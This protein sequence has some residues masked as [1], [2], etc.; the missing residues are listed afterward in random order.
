MLAKSL[1][2]QAANAVRMLR[3]GFTKL[4]AFQTVKLKIM[5]FINLAVF[6][7]RVRAVIKRFETNIGGEI[8]VHR[9]DAAD[10]KRSV[11]RRAVVKL[12]A[13]DR[14]LVPALRQ[15]PSDVLLLPLDRLP[16]FE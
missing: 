3:I 7:A 1:P 2:L 16:A 6:L 15:R 10:E 13:L 11:A 14:D 9:R 12:F 8:F 5:Q 4:D